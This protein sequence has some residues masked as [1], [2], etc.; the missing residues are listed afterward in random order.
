MCAAP[1][2][3]YAL[4]IRRT[5]GVVNIYLGGII[6]LG[7]KQRYAVFRLTALLGGSGGCE[8]TIGKAYLTG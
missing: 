5:D 1:L 8:V 4:L 2:F 3:A 6:A 7:N